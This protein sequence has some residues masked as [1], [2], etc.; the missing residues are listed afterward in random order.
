MEKVIVVNLEKCTGCRLC[1]LACAMKRENEC[2]P[3]LARIRIVKDE[4]RG[5]DVPVVCQQCENPSCM[6]VCPTDAIIRDAGVGIPTIRKEKCTGC[7]MCQIVC[8]VGAISLHPTQRVMFKCDL[9]DGEPECVQW[10]TT[11]AIRYVDV[12]EMGISKSQN[13][14]SK[15]TSLIK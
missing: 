3:H 6:K 14:L 15:V 1:E 7:R 11:Q 8:P 12:E 5:V 2:N 10:C 4:E 9:C 13:V